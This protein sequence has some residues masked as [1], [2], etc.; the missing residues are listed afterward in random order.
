MTSAPGYRSRDLRHV[1]AVRGCYLDAL[2]SWDWLL[3][4]FPRGIVPTDIDGLVEIN[5]HLLFL[6]E[7]GA[8]VVSPLGQRLALKALATRARTSVVHWRP[9]ERTE[10]EV[11]MFDPDPSGWEPATRAELRAWCASWARNA[12][13][14]HDER[15]SQ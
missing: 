5:D 3:G 2:P 6:E 9:G 1:C 13:H 12:D 7:K 4:A 14:G 11:L 10:L 15:A 8:G